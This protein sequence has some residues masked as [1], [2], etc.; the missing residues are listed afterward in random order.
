MSWAVGA[1]EALL[2][3]PTVCARP[4]PTRTRT[5]ARTPPLPLLQARSFAE[6][7]R[8]DLLTAEEGHATELAAAQL[9]STRRRRRRRRRR[10]RR[11]ACTPALA[12]IR[13]RRCC[14]GTLLCSLCGAERDE[15][16]R[17]SSSGGRGGAEPREVTRRLLTLHDDLRASQVRRWTDGRYSARGAPRVTL[18]LPLLQLAALRTR[19]ELATLRDERPA[20]AQAGGGGA[21]ARG[22]P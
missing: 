3:P 7:M 17:S 1:S 8:A 21:C 18:P 22:G 16:P 19:R 15:G 6:R 4:P 9:E 10:W 14:C 13:G 5:H 20:G 2:T 11:P 12:D